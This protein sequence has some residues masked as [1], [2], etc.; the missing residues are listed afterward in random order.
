M[1]TKD[2]HI[3]TPPS[4]AE[5]A[6]P[7]FYEKRPDVPCEIKDFH[8]KWIL[9]LPRVLTD[10]AKAK[11]GVKANLLEEVRPCVS[12]VRGFALDDYLSLPQ[13]AAYD[14]FSACGDRIKAVQYLGDSVRFLDG[15][16]HNFRLNELDID[17]ARYA[18]FKTSGGIYI[19]FLS[20]K[21]AKTDIPAYGG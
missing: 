13:E 7:Y 19:P 2:H 12:W 18:V 4:L 16:T 15:Y 5:K 21:I 9:S 10:E 20:G 1:Q 6:Q 3:L 14:I 8:S 11:D 17:D